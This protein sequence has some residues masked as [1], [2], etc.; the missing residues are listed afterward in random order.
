MAVYDENGSGWIIQASSD[1]TLSLLD[2]QNGTLVYSMTIE[3]TI[4]GSPAVYDDI[5]VIG[6]QGK[7]TSFIYG[8][9]L[10]G[11]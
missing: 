5:L 7:D 10:Q 2:G 3:G 6:T 8:I 11:R 4:N 9:K 1:G